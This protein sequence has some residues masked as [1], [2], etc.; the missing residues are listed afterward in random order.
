MKGI[1]FADKT[2]NSLYPIINNSINKYILPVYDKPMIYYPMST[3]IA[4]GIRDICIISCP[5]YL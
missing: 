4:C 2:N 1:V 3:L 5:E